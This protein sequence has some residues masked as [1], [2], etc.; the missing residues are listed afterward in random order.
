MCPS[1]RPLLGPHPI[2]HTLKAFPNFLAL[3]KHPWTRAGGLYP[4]CQQSAPV[5]F[6]TFNKA[7]PESASGHC[8]CLAGGAGAGSQMIRR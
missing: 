8:G 1:S 5:L 3:E 6:S 2:S 4:V 7:G